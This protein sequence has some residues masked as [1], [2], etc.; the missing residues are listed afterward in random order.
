[1][2]PKS[3]KVLLDVLNNHFLT[4]KV[5]DPR[6]L[7]AR[8]EKKMAIPGDI[9]IAQGEPGEHFYVLESG[10][11]DVIKDAVKIQSIA[12][13]R[14]FGDLALL[15]SSARTATIKARTVCKL[16]MLDRTSLRSF[17]S[18]HEKTEMEEKLK[19]L[20]SVKLFDKFNESTL[21]RI[22]EVMEL[23]N[24][25]KN[26]IIFRRGETGE[27][28]YMVQ[29]G[30]VSIYQSSLTGGR[31]ELVRMG[32]GKFFGE[33]ALLNNAPRG[34]S[35]CTLDK[36][37]CWI[38]DRS[39]FV[40]LVGSVE[41]ARGESIGV[42]ILKKVKLMQGISEKHLVT[43]SRR[44][45][46]VE[47]SEGET[48]INQG[49]DGD[50]FY[51]VATGEVK[52]EINHV[53]VASLGEG[54]FF[55]EA[56]LMKNE[57]R[58]ATVIA[59]LPVTCL[60]ITRSDFTGPILGP[61]AEMV[62]D[63]YNGF[64]DL[65]QFDRVRILGRGTFSNVYLVS[66]T[67]NE[68]FYALKVCVKERLHRTHQEKN[69]FTER[70]LMKLFDSGW[71]AAL[72]ASFQDEKC[73]YLVQQ[74]IP[75]GDL[76]SLIQSNHTSLD[77]T[78]QGGFDIPT[79][80]FYFAN[81]IVILTHLHEKDVVFRDLKPENFGLDSSGYLRLYDFGSAK[82]LPGDDS[83]NTM[84]GVAEYLSPEMITS[85]PHGRGTDF[86]ALGV[87]LYELM[88]GKTPFDHANS[89]M[90]YQNI[91]DSDE[92]L[93]VSFSK[94]FDSD[95]S[96]LIRMLL[97]VNPHMRLGMLRNGF[98]DFWEQPLLANHGATFKL[99]QVKSLVAPYKP[100]DTTQQRTNLNDLV[101]GNFDTDI[102]PEYT[103]NHDF[104]KF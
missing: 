77:K 34:A 62:R 22:A 87:L 53:Q 7:L 100:P 86:W 56:S 50:T 30:K 38:V 71:F 79:V 90:I 57:K 84:V 67:Q 46:T 18:H 41:E 37:S 45:K 88:T 21:E 3:E 13:G 98:D 4:K 8:F 40:A 9:I 59:S 55:G 49:E 69:V 44:L 35:A 68:T 60:S 63:K 72:Y 64:F 48:I 66:H 47:F 32:P 95:I 91:M 29:K 42:E 74:F 65:D 28:F 58:S 93:K 92:I 85:K 54:A 83:S 26:E 5:A 99:T 23:K 73:V 39:H 10:T 89:A 80:S 97:V 27:C 82:L 75:G 36:T 20:S 24:F 25:Q 76:F 12:P 31:T 94:G 15:T 104:S 6:E 19:F 61:I 51:M 33:L 43:V 70:D 17:L 1:M 2:D 78:R 16:W 102:I 52:V 81:I 101:I 14:S 96:N 11:A 103:G